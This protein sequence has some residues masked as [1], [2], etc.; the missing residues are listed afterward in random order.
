MSLEQFLTHENRLIRTTTGSLMT[1]LE[2]EELQLVFDIFDL[3]HNNVY[4]LNIR[5]SGEIYSNH[6]LRMMKSATDLDIRDYLTYVYIVIHD[7][8]EEYF[9]LQEKGTAGDFNVLLNGFNI[10]SNFLEHN[11]TDLAYVFVPGL[12]KGTSKVG[13]KVR[14]TESLLL[15]NDLRVDMVKILD[16]QDNSIDLENLSS[17]YSS[18]GKFAQNKILLDRIYKT[19]ESDF[20]IFKSDE[21]IKYN[22]I[23]ILKNI[24]NVQLDYIIV[25]DPK[26]KIKQKIN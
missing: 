9:K 14:Q 23:N 7:A 15:L 3:C 8:F 1:K 16:N 2:K 5:R 25:N 24:R 17:Y 26:N 12:F 21:K 10:Y 13:Q 18:E 6:I 4:G 22:L 19:K 20:N 11:I